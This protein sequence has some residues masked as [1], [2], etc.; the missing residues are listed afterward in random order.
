MAGELGLSKATVWIGLWIRRG[1]Y[2]GGALVGVVLLVVVSLLGW[3]HHSATASLPALD[4][5]ISLPGL[6]A[7]VTVRRDGHGVPHIEA[8]TQDD[9]LMAQGYV[10]AQD[11]MFQMDGLRRNAAGELAEVIGPTMVEHDK[12]Q[13]VLQFRSVAQR[14]YANLSEADRHRYEEYARGVN[15]YIAQNYDHLP[16]EFRLLH[17][18]PQPW[19]GVDSVLVALNM[20]AELDTHWYSKLMRERVA[21]NLHDAKLEADLYPV[22]SWRD[23]PPASAVADMTEPHP[24]PPMDADDD[25]EQTRLNALPAVGEDPEVLQALLGLPTCAGCGPAGQVAAGSNNWVIAGKHTASGKPLLSNDMHLGLT[26]PNIWYMAELKAPGVHVTGVTLPGLPWVVAGHNEHV[27]WGFTALY[28]DVQD[29]YVEK[30]DGKGNYAGPNGEW[31]PLAHSHEVI[32]VRLGPNVPLDLD[33]TGH[34]P[35]L[36]PIFK[37]EKRPISLHWTIYDPALASVPL[38]EMNTAEDASHFTEALDGWCFPT[39][40]VVYADANH[41]AYHAVGKVPERPNGLAGTPITDNN[42]EWQGYI[43]FEDL[44][45]DWDPKSGLL[46]TANSRVTPNDTKQPIT[47]EWADPYRAERV[48]A[49]LRGRNGLTREDMLAIETDIYSQVDQ[50]IAQRLAYAIDNAEG[51]EPRVKQAAD[52]LRSWDGRLTTDSAAASVVVQARHAFWPLI[53]KPKLGDDAES[54]LWSESNYAEEELIMH[55]GEGGTGNGTDGKASPWLPQGYK[56]WDALL[57]D[58]VRQGMKQGNAP[59][60][61]SHWAYGNWHVIDL[62]HPLLKMIPGL[63][64]WS[65]TGEQPLS[66][67]TTTVKQVGREFGPSQRFTM[68]WSAPDESTENIV[69]GESGDPASEWFR[70]Q[71]PA[72]YGGTTFALP[73][74]AGAVA[75]ATTHTLE[76]VP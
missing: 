56:D 31:L 18:H 13:R 40:N 46:A 65:G 30:L 74:S 7:P 25:S 8:A 63:K 69:L 6:T 48:Y 59:A 52:L 39:L 70:D 2:T 42:H 22:G 11:R 20:V 33:M 19:R 5:K 9:L 37:H 61:L 55:G 38:Y 1:L 45:H 47:L 14:I 50:E 67:D 32:K 21:A 66:G 29:L 41:I 36:T 51:V 27:A 76:L 75:K 4:G 24:A 3:I 68:D 62:E 35:I 58:A 44:P 15:L 57:T 64:A 26:V 17:Y 73:F 43:P 54:Y 49:D 16:A 53:L 23:Q 72:W 34:G 12:A 10:T 28:A 71:W 60:D